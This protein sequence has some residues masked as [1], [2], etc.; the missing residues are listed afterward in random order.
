[1]KVILEFSLPEEEEELKTALDADKW[2]A[3]V[4]EIMRR[5]RS[6]MKHDPTLSQAAYDEIER[7]RKDIQQ[8][9]EDEDLSLL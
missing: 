6:R 1:M 2:K 4:E 5:T 8:I 9:L 7:L 3:V